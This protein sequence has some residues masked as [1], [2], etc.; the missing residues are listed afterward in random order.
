MKLV[1]TTHKSCESHYNTTTI[2]RVPC[3]EEYRAVYRPT[4]MEINRATEA[5]LRGMRRKAAADFCV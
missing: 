5:Q 3:Y 1:Y 2:F 4:M